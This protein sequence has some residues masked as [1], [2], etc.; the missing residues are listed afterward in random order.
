[1]Q[2]VQHLRKLQRFDVFEVHSAMGVFQ[3]CNK[4]SVF[5]VYN[6]FGDFSVCSAINDWEVYTR[7][8]RRQDQDFI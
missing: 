8:H 4:L 7:S 1:V 6:E 2:R 3:V 5:E